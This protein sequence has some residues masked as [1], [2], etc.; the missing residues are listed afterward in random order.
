MTSLQTLNRTPDGIACNVA[1]TD[2]GSGNNPEIR[3]MFCFVIYQVLIRIGWIFKTETVIMPAILDAVADSGFLR[4]LLP[5]LN[6]AGQSMTQLLASGRLSRLKLQKWVLVGTS[7]SMAACFAALSL[8]WVS[9]EAFYPSLLS[10]L[11]LFL[12]GMFSISNGL[13]QL[14]AASLQGKLIS[15]A[16]RGRL[17]LVSV[18]MGSIVAVSVAIVFLGPWLETKAD[19]YKIFAASSLFFMFGA[20]VPIFFYEPALDVTA[21]LRNN[22]EDSKRPLWRRVQESGRRWKTLL[23]I[24]R[25]LVQLCLVAAS[26]SAALIIFPHYQAFARE[27]FAVESSSLITWVIVQNIATGLVSL[28][29]GP[30]SDQQGTRIVLIWLVFLSSLTPITVLIL[31]LLPSSV[32]TNLFWLVYLPLGLNPITLK[33]ITNYTLELAPKMSD[34]AHYVSIVG[35]ALATPFLLSPVVGVAVDCI[36]FLPVF[37]CGAA[38]ILLSAVAATKLPEPRFR[39]VAS[40]NRS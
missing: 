27:R 20:A 31:S 23:V 32:A 16:R 1:T 15:P 4:G 34:Q 8:A 11:F 33:I 10:A 25:D 35:V 14:V 17:M 19:F 38:A 28:V 30:V 26:F 24:N 2:A 22:V 7:L 9:L 6:R 39:H 12:Y 36:G 13:N 29:A 21:K 40:C 3:N 18:T 37:I 5:I